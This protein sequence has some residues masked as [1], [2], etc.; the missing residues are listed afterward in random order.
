MMPDDGL[1][2]RSHVRFGAFALAAVTEALWSSQADT[3]EATDEVAARYAAFRCLLNDRGV[4]AAP[5]LNDEARTAPDGPRR[6]HDSPG[7]PRTPP[8]PRC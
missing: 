4:A 6:A 7:R 8:A 3:A 5:Y 1:P 2:R